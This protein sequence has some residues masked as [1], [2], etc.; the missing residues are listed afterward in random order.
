MAVIWMWFV[1][2]VSCSGGSVPRALGLRGIVE[3]IRGGASRRPLSHW[4]LP[5]KGITVVL[6]KKLLRKPGPDPT[7]CSLASCIKHT[8]FVLPPSP[9]TPV[10][11]GEDPHQNRADAPQPPKL[12]AKPMSPLK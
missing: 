8:Q 2:Q 1:P 9:S 6:W 3:W 11:S 12:P 10:S 5:S 7:Q 4:A